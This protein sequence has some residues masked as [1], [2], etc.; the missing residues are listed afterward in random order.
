LPTEGGF[1]VSAKCRKG[2]ISDVRIR[3]IV[4]GPCRVFHP[5]PDRFVAVN[6][7]GE[8]KIV[9]ADGSSRFIEFLTRVGA[10]YRLDSQ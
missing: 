10:I 7:Q 6:E 1:R 4:G 3:S 2:E 8:R 9:S 5:W